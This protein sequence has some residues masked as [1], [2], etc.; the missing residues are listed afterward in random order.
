MSDGR[1]IADHKKRRAF[2][3]RHLYQ[4]HWISSGLCLIGM[5]LFAAT[6]ITL[7]HAGQIEAAPSVVMH[8]GQ[9][10]PP[11]QDALKSQ[12][13]AAKAPLPA[14]IDAW[15]RREMGVSVT[16]RDT[17]WS[18][19]DV[20]VA[21]PRPGGDAWLSIERDSGAVSYEVTDRGWIAYLNDLHKGRHTGRSWSWFLDLFAAA[22]MIFCLTGLLL[23]QLH[24][25]KRPATWPVV[26]LGLV[27]PLLVAV[28]FIHR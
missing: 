25:G 11:L 8:D 15:L 16:A 6:G 27:I 28:L 19:K 20:Y 1:R 26:G 4:W 2:F 10:P 13:A 22:A 12:P 24:A 9:L 18:A 14:E 23:L 5:L 7:N 21:L 17:E 3:L